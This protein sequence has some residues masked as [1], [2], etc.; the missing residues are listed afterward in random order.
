VKLEMPA[1]SGREDRPGP[2][3][4]VQLA[5]LGEALSAA[6]D[7]ALEAHTAL[8]LNEWRVLAA[9]CERP[10]LSPSD[11]ATYTG[12]TRTA[13]SRALVRL[14]RARW[15]TRTMDE[16]DAR[17]AHARPTTAGRRLHDELK[18]WWTEY[19]REVLAG[20]SAGGLTT[21]ITTLS[22][23]CARARRH[24][25][26]Q[27]FKAPE[28]SSDPDTDASTARSATGTRSAPRT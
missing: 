6:V 15:V 1:M 7:A 17:R 28:A 22:T 11:V 16:S 2:P 14:A 12:L 24:T 10:G 19:E 20:R 23:L 9:L 18:A 26:V 13:V 5:G 27:D 3:A 4:L 8:T 25:P 21:L